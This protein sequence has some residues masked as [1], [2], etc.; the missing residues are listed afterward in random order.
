ML[1][2]VTISDGSI[3]ETERD[4]NIAILVDILYAYHYEMR[5]LGFAEEESS[6][7]TKNII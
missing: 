7:S 3:E 4:S 5:M 2:N 1:E 6:E